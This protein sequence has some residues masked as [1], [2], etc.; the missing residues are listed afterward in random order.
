MGVDEKRG[1]I[2][3]LWQDGPMAQDTGLKLT[4]A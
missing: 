2:A 3:L 4:N 1:W